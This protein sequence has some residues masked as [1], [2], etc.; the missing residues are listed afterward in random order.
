MASLAAGNAAGNAADPHRIVS[1]KVRDAFFRKVLLQQANKTCFDCNAKN[2]KWASV[3]FG[4]LICLGC[5][6][7][8]RRMGVHISFVRSVD[9]DKWKKSELMAMKK[10]GNKRAKQFFAEHGWS[11]QRSSL[12]LIQKKYSSTA[13]RMYKSKLA[14]A[15]GSATQQTAASPPTSPAA[16]PAPAAQDMDAAKGMEKLLISASVKAAEADG[17]NTE[18]VSSLED[19]DKKPAVRLRQDSGTGVLVVAGDASGSAEATTTSTGTRG[20]GKKSVLKS[21]GK[22]K[23]RGKLGARRIG[24][25]SRGA[26]PA[27]TESQTTDSDD[28]E[29]NLAAQQVAVARAQQE[30]GVVHKPKTKGIVDG[31]TRYQAASR[32][33]SSQA[34]SFSSSLSAAPG[35]VS[36]TRA[37]L[38]FSAS[39]APKPSKPTR[40]AKERFANRKGISSDMFF[41]DG[42]DSAQDRF[43][44]EGKRQQFQGRGAISSDMYFGRETDNR[45]RTDSGEFLTKAADD[46]LR[47][48]SKAQDFF[49]GFR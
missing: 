25:A 13:A 2:P 5:S 6:G 22:F 45:D 32:A 39:A 33:T 26:K 4:V 47:L 43:E 9:M 41:N 12:D 44:R 14:K 34:S 30:G 3:T 38:G 37:S 29:V 21:K 7:H 17:A 20:T 10:G 46:L 49:Q 15:V 28:F 31:G 42:E 36:G 1:N 16:R 23:R 18:V 40:S 11:E 19:L 24:G 8:H 48:K 27:A 35:S